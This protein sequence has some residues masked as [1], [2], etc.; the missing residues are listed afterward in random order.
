MKKNKQISRQFKRVCTWGALIPV[1]LLSSCTDLTE[2]INN[3]VTTENF[4]QTDEE[5]ISAL[6]DAYDPLRSHGT[7]TTLMAVNEVSSDEVLVSQKGP[8]WED[9]G[10]WLR[11][12]RH[13][14]LPSEDGIING[15][16]DLFSGVNNA[17]RLIFQLESEEDAAAFIAELRLLRAYYYYM[18]LDNY[19][20]VPIVESFED[21]PENPSQPSSN[22]EEGRRAVFEFVESEVMETLDLVETD[23]G[24]TYGRVNKWVGHMIL[25]KLYLNAEIYTGTPRWEDVITQTDMIINSGNYSLAGNYSDNFAVDNSGS[26]ENMFVVPFDQVFRTGFNLHMMTMHILSQPAFNFGSQPW[27]GYQTVTEFYGSYIDS[28]T[29]PGPQGD[30]VG[31]DPE[32]SMVTGTLDDR[33]SNFLVGPLL[34][35]QGN[36]IEDPGAEGSDPN[37]PPITHTP[38]LNEMAPNGWRQ[39]GARITKYEMEIGLSGSDM[40]NDY[41]I[42]RYGDVLLMKAEALWRQNPGDQTALMLVNQ[43]RERAGVDPFNSLDADKLLAERGREMFFELVRRQDLIRFPGKMGATRFNDTWRFKENVSEPHKN[44]FPIP[45]GQL[46]ANPNLVQNPGY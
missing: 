37:G 9:G 39:A 13:E 10:I 32:G 7:N 22:F 18:L 11:T 43:I 23:V 35:L 27:N 40:N 36:Q 15:W 46:E 2:N 34:N 21:S 42:F 30:V 4:F 26:P 31:L 25:A 14:F 38:Y 24:A 20:N 44:V 1:I 41:V 3:Q 33:L 8:D 45:Q 5:F 6:G 17:N 29:N 16:N 28:E 19:G 12:H